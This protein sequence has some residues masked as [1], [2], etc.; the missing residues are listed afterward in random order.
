M[1]KL[2]IIIP[3]YNAEAYLSRCLDSICTSHK[4][5]VEIICVNDGSTDGSSSLLHERVGRDQRMV[6]IEQ[7]NKGTL[8]SRKVGVLAAKGD[9]VTFIDP[10]DWFADD[11]I[12]I[13]T[14]TSQKYKADIIMFGTKAEN[15]GGVSNHKVVNYEKL[16]NSFPEALD[17]RQEMIKR[18]FVDRKIEWNIW[19]KA[20]KR[21]LIQKAF[22]ELPDVRC[23]YAEDR[24][25]MFF[26]MAF[27]NTFRGVHRQLWHYSFGVGVSSREKI[28]IKDYERMFTSLDL[29]RHTREFAL[30]KFSADSVEVKSL[31]YMNRHLIKDVIYNMY[32]RVEGLNN[33]KEAVSIL[34]NGKDTE[35]KMW[36]Y[37][38]VIYIYEIL[39]DAYKEDEAVYVKKNAKHLRLCRW[40]GIAVGVLLI[41]ICILLMIK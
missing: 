33:F 9:Y 5:E 39:S 16:Q 14:E 13:I 30:S 12:D 26:I 3:I 38:I 40:L 27:A 23:V 37:G 2:S 20:Y 36:L 32:Q 7:E 24:Y 10:D 35:Y 1:I 28:T 22:S 4:D 25:S 31:D 6:L 18:C 8:V 19:G 17:D 15:T 41:M 34:S 11:A 29:G 21:E